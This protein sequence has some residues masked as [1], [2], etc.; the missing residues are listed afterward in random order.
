MSL[1]WV[2][3]GSSGEQRSPSTEIEAQLPHSSASLLDESLNHA[4]KWVA[5]IRQYFL[6][7]ARQRHSAHTERNKVAAWW[8]LLTG[9]SAEQ[10]GRPGGGGVAEGGRLGR[11]CTG[12][13][14]GE[15]A[16]KAEERHSGSEEWTAGQQEC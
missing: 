10:C 15:A 11:E 12:N 2:E 6:S 8:G 3:A 13:V 5:A 7:T 9:Q 14:T 1:R 16:L 4:D